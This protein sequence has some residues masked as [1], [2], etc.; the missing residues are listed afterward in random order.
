MYCEFHDEEISARAGAKQIAELVALY[1]QSANGSGRPSLAAIGRDKIDAYLEDL[2]ILQPVGGDFI[3]RHYGSNVA[4][5]AG[6]DMTG[7]RVSEFEGKV[8]EFFRSC[9]E[10]ALKSG[11]PLH[12]LHCTL[13]EADSHLWERLL[14]PVTDDEG[15]DLL[16]VFNSSQEAHF[17]A[18]L[19]DTPALANLSKRTGKYVDVHQ[20]G[21]V[22]C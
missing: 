8:A 11:R 3:Y 10:R 4:E 15:N 17:A 14:L 12:T 21:M 22:S 6:I 9:Y 13:D 16:V 1:T 18:D 20:V 2:A 7:R 19:A 5:I